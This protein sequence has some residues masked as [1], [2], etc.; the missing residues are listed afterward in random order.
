MAADVRQRHKPASLAVQVMLAEGQVLH[1]RRLVG[2]RAS[3]LGQCIQSQLTSP[4]MLLL[5]GGLGFVAGH[6]TKRQASAPSNTKG[7][8]ASHNKLFGKALK[9]IALAR[10]LS[11]SFPSAV[12]D[13]SVQS[14]LPSQPP[15][16]RFGSAAAS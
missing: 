15:E 9:L 11:R 7:P 3:L 4:A 12:M 1:R 10:I 13:P 8:R 16:P 14:G 6:F 2:V 5:A